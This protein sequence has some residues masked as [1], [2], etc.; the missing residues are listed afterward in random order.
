MKEKVGTVIGVR[1]VTNPLVASAWIIALAVLAI[2]SSTNQI[3]ADNYFFFIAHNASPWIVAGMW[4]V[5]V[6]VGLALLTGLLWMAQRLGPRAFDIIVTTVT[7]LVAIVLVGSVIELSGSIVSWQPFYSG[8]VR[9]ALLL[10][11][12]L[13]LAIALVW[14]ASKALHASKSL[15]TANGTPASPKAPPIAVSA[16]VIAV[17]WLLILAFLRASSAVLTLQ[18]FGQSLGRLALTL[19]IAAGF[20]YLARRVAGGIA[21]LVISLVVASVPLATAS[22]SEIEST[23][24]V[25]VV[26]D[27]SSSRPDILWII[28]DELSYPAV[29]DSDGKVRDIF[30]NIAAIQERSTTYTEAYTPADGTAMAIPAILNGRADIS[31]L[32]E[33]ARRAMQD[34][35]GVLNWLASRYAIASL[36]DLFN[37]DREGEN[38]SPQD[39][40]ILT[41]LQMGPLNPSTSLETEEDHQD[42][43]DSLKLLVAD[44]AAV[45]GR[46]TLHPRLAELF[47]NT[48]GR[49]SNYWRNFDT[50]AEATEN[51]WLQSVAGRPSPLLALWHYMGVHTPLRRDMDGLR[52][53]VVSP[54]TGWPETS[55]PTSIEAADLNRRLYLAEILEFDKRL[56]EALDVWWSRPQSQSSMIVFTSDHGRTFS[57][58]ANGQRDGT[59]QE[60]WTETAHVPLMVRFP[61]QEAADS[62]DD[63]VSLGQIAATVLQ[64]AGVESLTGPEMSPALGVPLYQAPLPVGWDAKEAD[65]WFTDGVDLREDPWSM[66]TVASV[67][68][69]EPFF[70]GHEE[71]L[72]GTPVPEGFTRLEPSEV[73]E[74]KG[75]SSYLVVR[76][77]APDAQCPSRRPGLVTQ[78]SQVVGSILWETD[79]NPE[80]GWALW[81]ASDAGGAEYWCAPQA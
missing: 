32:D 61:G 69:D 49:W 27:E 12:S 20:T 42:R 11:I 64:A 30:P 39:S 54:A 29:F 77:Q 21:A 80:Q 1:R 46:T 38:T 2:V 47:P 67:N 28:V 75:E 10:A 36:S 51:D 3:L 14:I 22:A 35:S 62:V 60:R 34:S 70:I 52:L 41:H 6:A 18:P 15:L 31:A 65:T 13:A 76:I 56:G 26:F 43:W 53:G 5:L 72:I 71:S 81:R 59:L 8:P 50:A 19:V 78:D 33:P 73:E 23:G 25:S 68:S 9:W 58:K 55:V 57:P 66:S 7:L 24:P 45:A 4:A 16:T 40:G 37:R 48:Q 17:I 79:A 74:W 63:V 44:T